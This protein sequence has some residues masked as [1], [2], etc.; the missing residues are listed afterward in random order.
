MILLLSKEAFKDI[1]KDAVKAKAFNDLIKAQ[2][3]HSKGKEIVYRELRLQN[4]LK[5]D[6]PLTRKEKRFLFAARTRGLDLKN[7]F[8]VGKANLQCR[9]CKNHIEDQ[10]SLLTC[11][12]LVDI[13]SNV[14]QT[15]NDIFSDDI[16]KLT[17]ITK[18]LHKKYENFSFQVS[19]QAS[20]PSSS[21]TNVINNIMI[22]DNIVD[23]D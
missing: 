14:Q 13:D 10:E 5:A 18:V 1:I 2:K 7:N 6:S 12:A 21:A 20:K 22:V 8:K 17:T 11:Q 19:R 15:Y 3:G 4:Y 23:L 9:L 16:G